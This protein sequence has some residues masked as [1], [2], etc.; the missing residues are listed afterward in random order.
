MNIKTNNQIGL[1]ATVLTLTVALGAC[2]SKPSPWSQQGSPWSE[3]KAVTVDEAPVTDQAQMVEE[4]PATE[5]APAPWVTEP[6]ATAASAS[7]EDMARPEPMMEEVVPMEAA[8]VNATEMTAEPAMSAAGDIMSQPAEYFTV[9]VCASSGMDKLMAFAKSN[10]L[11]D[12][13]TAQTNV[14]G[15]VWYVLMLGVY[16]TRA[17]ADAA[18]SF[19]SDK[20]LSTQPWI[21]TVGSVQAAAQ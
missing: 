10:D 20:N 18:M 3:G 12:Q 14:N 7:V 9:Q 4:T 11:P 5:E 19:I 21:R 1:L 8:A 17:E 2:S 6:E 16:P 13:W 15:K